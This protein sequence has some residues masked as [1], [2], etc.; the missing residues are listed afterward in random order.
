MNRYVQSLGLLLLIAGSA[1]AQPATLYDVVWLVQPGDTL[2]ITDNAGVRV[3]GKLVQI[4]TSSLMLDASRT[5]YQ[6]K[7]SDIERIER[8]GDSL[9]NGALI[10]AA[11]AIASTL[12]VCRSM[13]PWKVCLNNPNI[14][15][16]FLTGAVG[17]GMGVGIDALIRGDR[18]LYARPQASQPSVSVAP[19]FGR[20]QKGVLMSVR[21]PTSTP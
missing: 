5:L 12:L 16:W 6:F 8:R 2:T 18:V 11:G 13:E 1:E 9:M 15:P 14:A 17:A 21:L 19:I 10:G 20:G 7:E 4:S 3:R